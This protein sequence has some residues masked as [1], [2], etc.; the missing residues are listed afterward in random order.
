[1]LIPVLLSWALLIL[2]IEFGMWILFHK[3]VVRICIPSDLTVLR[4]PRVSMAMLWIFAMFHTVFLLSVVIT[5]H[6]FL[7]S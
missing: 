5:A 4:R 3:G 6:L 1:M 2:L 7:W